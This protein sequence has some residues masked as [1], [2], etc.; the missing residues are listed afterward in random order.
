LKKLKIFNTI[1]AIMLII[2][3][4]FLL[5]ACGDGLIVPSESEQITS[6]ISLKEALPSFNTLTDNV[7]Y[8]HKIHQTN[9]PDWFNYNF[10]KI[11]N[12]DILTRSSRINSDIGWQYEDT[13]FTDYAD[14]TDKDY[15]LYDKQTSGDFIQYSKFKYN[16][17]DEDFVKYY[18]TDQTLYEI[19]NRANSFLFDYSFL[20]VEDFE[21]AERTDDEGTTIPYWKLKSN[22]LVDA[23]FKEAVSSAFHEGYTESAVNFSYFYI[24]V[25]DNKVSNIQFGYFD[26]TNGLNLM[27]Y[28][29]ITYDYENYQF[30]TAMLSSGFTLYESS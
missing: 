30:D 23:E 8:R 6:G 10:V 26:N 20:N 25:T 11:D 4:S 13:I 18:Y 28:N 21:Y 15:I 5:S 9:G 16:S 3:S 7:L 17:T 22:L 14:L 24:Y 27:L 19:N 29:D 1:V 12:G 2:N